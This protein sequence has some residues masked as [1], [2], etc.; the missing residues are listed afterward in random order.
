M[1]ASQPFRRALAMVAALSAAMALTGTQKELALNAIGSYQSRGKG[2]GV[3]SG[4]YHCVAQDKRAAKKARNI[5][6]HK[7][8]NSK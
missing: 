5:R 6:R 4:S 2:R 7:S 8:L 3:R 1:Q